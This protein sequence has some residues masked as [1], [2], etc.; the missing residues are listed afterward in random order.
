MG[1]DVIPHGTRL[2]SGVPELFAVL[3]R[4][5]LRWLCRV[6]IFDAVFP[7]KLAQGSMDILA[8]ERMAGFRC[9]NLKEIAAEFQCSPMK[10]MLLLWIRRARRSVTR[11]NTLALRMSV[12]WQTSRF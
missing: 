9:G 5:H 2:P 10:E 7:R 4:D 6:H 8:G 1:P 11:S 12:F 3:L